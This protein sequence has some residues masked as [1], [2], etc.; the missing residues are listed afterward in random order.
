MVQKVL[1][2]IVNDIDVDEEDADMSKAKS[3]EKDD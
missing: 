2:A 1:N 3:D